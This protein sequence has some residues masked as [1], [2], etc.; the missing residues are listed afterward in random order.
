VTRGFTGELARWRLPKPQ[1]VIDA[2]G[3]Q[4]R[5]AIVPR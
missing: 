4:E 1:Q 5:C 3:D 2:C